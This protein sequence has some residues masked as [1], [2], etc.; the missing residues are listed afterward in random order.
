MASARQRKKEKLEHLL[1]PSA[2][3]LA[4]YLFLIDTN[5]ADANQGDPLSIEEACAQ[6][7]IP[8]S[9]FYSKYRYNE[10]FI[11]YKNLLSEIFLDEKL[12]KVAERLMDAVDSGNVKAIE[13]YYRKQGQL[14]DRSVVETISTENTTTGQTNEDIENSLH[15]VDDLLEV[16]DE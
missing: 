4:H 6:A 3:L 11:A 7:K 1:G 13:L 9:T 15:E 2:V 5:A 16:D 12:P 8:K 14:K 10:D